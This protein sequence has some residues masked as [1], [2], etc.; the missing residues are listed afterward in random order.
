MAQMNE[1]IDIRYADIFEPD[2][3]YKLLDRYNCYNNIKNGSY[4]SF[5]I[6][7][8]LLGFGPTA[9]TIRN[10]FRISDIESPE[11][12]IEY[13]KYIY[14]NH[15]QLIEFFSHFNPVYGNHT[16]I[17]KAKMPAIKNTISRIKHILL[18]K[19]EIIPDILLN[20]QLLENFAINKGNR[21]SFLN[22]K[23]YILSN[24]NHE[25]GPGLL[26]DLPF[27]HLAKYNSIP[28]I[29]HQFLAYNNDVEKYLKSFTIKS[30][31]KI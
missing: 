9:P 2:D 30:L 21:T 4:Y 6:L 18:N 29:F 11:Y 12:I 22:T 31:K 25:V 24:A 8:H 26:F 19:N 5:Q 13:I 16:A 20:N 23:I 28:F 7:V 14:D 10:R 3:I 27:Q 1:Y 17:T 15:E